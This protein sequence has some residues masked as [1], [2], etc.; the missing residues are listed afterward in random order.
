MMGSHSCSPFQVMVQRRL[1]AMLAAIREMVTE[2]MVRKLN[3]KKQSLE[4]GNVHGCGEPQD[5][6]P[7]SPPLPP[8]APA[9]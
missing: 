6:V 9:C 1:L 3:K 8:T 2:S 4:K 5:W 7:L